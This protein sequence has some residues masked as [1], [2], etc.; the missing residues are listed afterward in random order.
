MSA[1]I[2]MLRSLNVI[3]A[4]VVA[5]ASDGVAVERLWPRVDEI[6]ETVLL[7][8]HRECIHVM[9]TRDSSYFCTLRSLDKS[10]T[11]AKE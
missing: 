9:N 1:N 11:Y 8:Y 6:K 5:L 7:C 4:G 2:I 10:G 3:G